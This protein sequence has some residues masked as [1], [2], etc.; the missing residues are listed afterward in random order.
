MTDIQMNMC[1][2][3]YNQSHKP[4]ETIRATTWN[5]HGFA[6]NI[7]LWYTVCHASRSWVKR[8]KILQSLRTMKNLWPP[9]VTTDVHGSSSLQLHWLKKYLLVWE[10]INSGIDYMQQRQD[11]WLSKVLKKRKFWTKHTR[12]WKP[13]NLKHEEVR[14]G[15]KHAFGLFFFQF[16]N[17][18]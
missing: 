2:H 6:A 4:T 5:E 1:R 3:V 10:C 15:L 16:R 18:P 8:L 17:L 7:V 12:W 9:D 14:E 13:P 11:L